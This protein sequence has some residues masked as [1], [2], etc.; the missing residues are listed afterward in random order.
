MTDC[1]NDTWP[2]SQDIK[3]VSKANENVARRMDKLACYDDSCTLDLA[4]ENVSQDLKIDE[5][6]KGGYEA[7]YSGDKREECDLEDLEE[8]ISHGN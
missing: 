3:S 7:H 1:D 8:I 4:S 5:S 6:V 2:D